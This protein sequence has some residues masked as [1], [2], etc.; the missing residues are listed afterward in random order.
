M[1][2]TTTPL[3][4]LVLSALGL[5]L[6]GGEAP[7]PVIALFVGALA[8]AATAFI[9]IRLGGR[10]GSFPAGIAAALIWA[11]HPWSVTFAIGGMETSLFVA[12]LGATFYLHLRGQ[13]VGA[14][15]TSGLA[16]LT[17]PDGLLFILPLA[18][19]RAFV[20]LRYRQG[21]GTGPPVRWTE[22]AAFGAPVGLWAM[23]SFLI[24]DSPIPQSVFA[25][26]VAYRLPPEAGLVRLMQH[27][28]TPFMG[29]GI[30]GIP[31]IAVG[32]ILFPTLFVLGALFAFRS[33]RRSWPLW[34]YPWI[35]LA[36]YAIANPLLFRWYLVPPML[37]YIL[38]IFLGAARLSRDFKHWLPLA[39]LTLF[40]LGST[41]QSW[42]LHPDHGPDRPAPEMAFIKLELLYQ[43][44]A[45][46]LTDRLESG[47]VVAAADIGALG[48]YSESRILDLLGLISPQATTFYPLPDSAYAINYAVPAGLVAAQQPEYLVILEVYGRNTL[49]LDDHFQ[50]SYRLDEVLNTD[51]YGSEGLLLFSRSEPPN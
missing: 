6:G 32:L 21:K 31:W 19:D 46:E 26:A 38:G 4:A 1:L 33:D 39:I 24:Y 23:A 30:L 42:T 3:F 29:H 18:I 9:L 40:G 10:L 8:D 49:L 5:P 2:G 28:A 34:T 37:A 50:S 43:Q 13:P 36:A 20:T 22:L 48:Y 15:A 17:R 35:Y 45:A 47:D 7:F 16:L 41:I 11:V 44:A 27:Y 14:A 25:K 51:I 12:L